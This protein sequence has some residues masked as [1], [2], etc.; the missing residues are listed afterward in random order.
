MRTL[1]SELGRGLMRNGLCSASSMGPASSS[2]IVA[3]RNGFSPASSMGSQ[4][5][6]VRRCHGLSRR[7]DLKPEISPDLQLVYIWTHRITVSSALLLPLLC[8][9]LGLFS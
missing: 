3:T 5:L 7:P 1:L 2:V 9:P 4:V 8:P 6:A